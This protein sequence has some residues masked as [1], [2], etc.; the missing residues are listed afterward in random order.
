MLE[1]VMLWQVKLVESVSAAVLAVVCALFVTAIPAFAQSSPRSPIAPP[2]TPPPA[3]K[4][5]DHDNDVDFGSRETDA[6]T[7][8]ILKAEKKAYDEHVA[9]AKEASD[10]AG[11][12]KTSYAA[13][14]IFNAADQKKLE[15]LE[16][17]TKRIRNE[18]GGSEMDADPKDLPSTVPDGINAMADMAKELYDEVE[19]TPRRVVS[20]SLIE[21]AN[22]LLAVIQ[23]VRGPRH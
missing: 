18:V 9:R 4:Q 16:K 1:Q 21:Q 10:L 22:K 7:R 23:F 6:R 8:L 13:T 15:R 14:N 17:L 2:P 3:N 11:Q 19:K 12:L 5:D 20:A